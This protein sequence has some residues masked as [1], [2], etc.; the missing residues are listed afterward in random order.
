MV[1]WEGGDERFE[2]LKE[3]RREVRR[4]GKERR[5]RKGRKRKLGRAEHDVR[6]SRRIVGS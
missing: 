2:A 6:G 1:R 4:S 5:R 3:G